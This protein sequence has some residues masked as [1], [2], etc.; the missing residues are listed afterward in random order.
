M[1]GGAQ[2]RDRAATG[3]SVVAS[4]SP[5]AL[6]EEKIPLLDQRGCVLKPTDIAGLSEIAV[7]EKR[8]FWRA[9]NE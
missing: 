4:K 5:L 3:E 8:G 6:N 2:V 7:Y 1:H 9:W